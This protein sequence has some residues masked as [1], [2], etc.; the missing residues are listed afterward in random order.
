MRTHMYK[1]TSLYQKRIKECLQIGVLGRKE[2]ISE[3]VDR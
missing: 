2:M 1:Y 3:K